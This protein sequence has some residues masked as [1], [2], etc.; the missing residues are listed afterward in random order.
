VDRSMIM[1]LAC[2][3]TIRIRPMATGAR[4]DLRSASRNGPHDFGENARR[5]QGFSEAL[6]DLAEAR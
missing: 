6:R 1:R 5:V 2:D 4:V 3:V